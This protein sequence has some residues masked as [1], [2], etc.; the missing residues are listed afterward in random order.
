MYINSIPTEGGHFG[1]G[2]PKAVFY[3]HSF[4]TRVTK[5]HDFVHL[6]IPLI[7]VKL[8]LKKEVQN[9]KKNEKRKFTVL[10]PK[11]PPFGKKSRKI[12]KL[13]FFSKIHTFS[14]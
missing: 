10:T 1:P 7:P 6:S 14:T 3:F 9:F 13:V 11:G 8:I 5:I 2:Q 4:M 12:Q